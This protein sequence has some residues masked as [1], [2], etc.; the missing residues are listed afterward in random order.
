MRKERVGYTS[1]LFLIQPPK[2]QILAEGTF[3][4]SGAHKT[5]HISFEIKKSPPFQVIVHD[6]MGQPL[7]H[8][9]IVKFYIV[10]TPH[11]DTS[12]SKGI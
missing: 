5:R 4:N 3:I 11:P 7:L 1:S 2:P 9:F 8:V 12:S 6:L 10:L